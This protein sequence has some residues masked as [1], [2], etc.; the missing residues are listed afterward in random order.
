[1]HSLRTEEIFEIHTFVRFPHGWSGQTS[2]FSL[3]PRKKGIGEQINYFW[4][5]CPKPFLWANSQRNFFSDGKSRGPLS[6]RAALKISN[7]FLFLSISNLSK[8]YGNFFK[9]D[10]TNPQYSLRCVL[11]VGLRVLSHVVEFPTI[12]SSKFAP[13]SQLFFPQRQFF[14]SPN[15]SVMVALKAFWGARVTEV[16]NMRMC[17]VSW[18]TDS[19]SK[20]LY[21]WPWEWNI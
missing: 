19:C 5:M 18:M 9:T 3:R 21:K 13:D 8:V 6:A 1:M 11:L 20:L 7:S 14:S 16:R 17:I 15:W 2:I 10:A 12:C 4:N